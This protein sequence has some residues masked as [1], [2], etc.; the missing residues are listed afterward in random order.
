MNYIDI[1]IVG[2]VLF[3]AVKGFSKGFIIEAASLIAL[4]LGL[5]GALLFSSTVGTL[6]ES[7]FDTDRIPPS[8][9]LFI[10]T[11]IAIIIGINLLAKFLTRV[12]KMA[13]LGGLNRILGAIFGGLKFVLIL[14]AV[15]LIMDQ[16]E[17][18]F[19][20]ME[21]DVIEESQFYEPVK[22]IGSIVLEWLLD[23]KDLLPEDL[24]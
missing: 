11:F 23:K 12:L 13:A 15:I 24:V 5:I 4:I 10:L 16:F 14:S 22:S 1:A 2:L 7:Y 17:F 20:F 6:L 18:L 21:D 3:G 19:T 8:G 9:I